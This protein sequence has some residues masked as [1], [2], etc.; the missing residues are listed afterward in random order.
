MIEVEPATALYDSW[1]E[2]VEQT[3]PSQI[4]SCRGRRLILRVLPIIAVRT[5]PIFIKSSKTVKG[6]PSKGFVDYLFVFSSG[7]Y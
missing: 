1:S 7:L 4:N 6:L 3:Q 2:G 5:K